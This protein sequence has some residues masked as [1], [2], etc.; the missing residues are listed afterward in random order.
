MASTAP[1]T[2]HAIV[3]ALGDAKRAVD[4]GDTES[5][6]AT[7]IELAGNAP[8]DTRVLSSLAILRLHANHFE[9]ALGTLRD[10]EKIEPKNPQVHY[11]KGMAFAGVGDAWQAVESFRA[12]LSHRPDF[13]EAAFEIA[14]LLKSGPRKQEAYEALVAAADPLYE[15]GRFDDAAVLYNEALSIDPAQPGIA[16]RLGNA[17]LNK[18]VLPEA[19]KAFEHVVNVGDAD[20]GAKAHNALAVV[21]LR[22]DRL[23]DAEAE[24]AEALAGQTLFPQAYLNRGNLEARRGRHEQAVEAYRFATRQF[25]GYVDAWLNLALEHER[26]DE[27]DAALAA[28]DEVVRLD[29][30]HRQAHYVRARLLLRLGRYREGWAGYLW[31]WAAL[32]RGNRYAPDPR[33]EGRTLPLPRRLDYRELKGRRVVVLPEPVAGEEVSFLR[34]L[35]RLA[36]AGAK[37][38]VMATEPVGRMLAECADVS[39]FDGEFDAKDL[40]VPSGDLPY[41]LGIESA[42]DIPPPL[43]LAS[44]SLMGPQA[45]AQQLAAAGPGPYLALTWRSLGVASGTES[46]AL[47][48]AAVAALVR[49][50]PGTAIAVQAD[51]SGEECQ[52]IAE[53]AGRPVAGFGGQAAT[54]ATLVALLGQVQAFAGVPGL[55]AHL[56]GSAGLPAH[57]LLRPA[58]EWCFGMGDETPWYPE[59]ALVRVGSGEDAAC[60]AAEGLATRLAAVI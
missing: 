7:V 24:L 35:P 9:Q 37:V 58:D 47:P 55:A 26:H 16:Y 20:A 27:T 54:P 6:L 29:A 1:E 19:R 18:G 57:L 28:L 44:R 46:Q 5:A 52:A 40:I 13:G 8:D 30:S 56:A 10:W 15:A 11:H 51:A 43:P 53:L 32:G 23:E 36:E 4:A 38:S 3:A 45:A 42:A 60:A 22:E 25:P 39:L 31:R 41:V 14:R 34:F 50:W 12:A 17:Y 49:A 2:E 59:F 21:A 48:Q 33:A